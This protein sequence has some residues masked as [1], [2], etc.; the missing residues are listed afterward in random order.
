M[1]RTIQIKK[2]AAD[3]TIQV[4]L[5]DGLTGEPKT[6]VTIANL[7]L[8]YIRV[9]DDED[10]TISGKMDLT[11]LAALTDAHADNKAI[12][13]GKGYYRIDLPDAVFAGGATTSSIVIEDGTGNTILSERVDFQLVGFDPYDYLEA[14]IVEVNGSSDAA[15]SL[16]IASALRGNKASQNKFT[17]TITVRNIDDDADLYTVTLTDDGMNINRSIS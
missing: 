3:V 13:I 5:F 7:D 6:G 2:G 8:W 4:R 14:N 9:E 11:A 15:A 12:E 10:V 17:G 1:N 16:E